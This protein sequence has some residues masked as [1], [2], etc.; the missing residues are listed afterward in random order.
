[1]NIVLC[2]LYTTW[3]NVPKL[4]YLLLLLSCDYWRFSDSK[5]DALR[6]ATNKQCG[7]LAMFYILT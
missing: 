4:D 6:Y 5:Q 1:M 7:V 2:E 3:K